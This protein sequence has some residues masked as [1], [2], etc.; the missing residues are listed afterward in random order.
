M[1]LHYEVELG[2]V[3]GQMV[4]NLAQ[5]NERVAMDSIAG[6]QKNAQIMQ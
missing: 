5:D 6:A 1:E 2:L 4:R 3:M